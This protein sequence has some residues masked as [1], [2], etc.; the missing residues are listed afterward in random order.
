MFEFDLYVHRKPLY[1]HKKTL[2]NWF[3]EK[4]I[5]KNQFKIK[6]AFFQKVRFIFQISKFQKKMFQKTILSLKFKF[7]ANYTLLLLAGN[8][9][10]KFRIVFLEYFLG[11]DLK[12]TLYFLEASILDSTWYQDAQVHLVPSTVEYR[13]KK[14]RFKKESRFKKDCWY[15]RFS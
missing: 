1:R 4:K 11:G 5:N 3:P 2:K 15:N 8:L 14:A 7:P 6:V 9:N 10:F 13:F 12:N